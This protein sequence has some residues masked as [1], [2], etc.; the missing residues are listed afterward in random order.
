MELMDW[1][2]RVYV[3]DRRCKGGE[4]ILKT[5]AYRNKH[6]HW[7]LEEVRDLQ[8]GLYPAPRFRFEVDPTFVTVTS[9]QTG[10]LVRI[11]A[12]DRGGPCDP[13]MERFWTM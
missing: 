12:E 4:R 8:S 13:S 5:Y 7:M 11:R 1:T 2:M 6:L 10:E 3:Q 9:L